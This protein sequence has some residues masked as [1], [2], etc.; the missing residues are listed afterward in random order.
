[1]DFHGTRHLFVVRVIV[2]DVIADL[3]SQ[4]ES[5]FA[6]WAGMHR[7]WILHSLMFAPATF[8]GYHQRPDYCRHWSL[9]QLPSAAPI[10]ASRP[11]IGHC[12]RAKGGYRW[13]VRLDCLFRRSLPAGFP[14]WPVL[15]I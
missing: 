7:V 4:K 12:M 5:E 9:R 14:R 10:E 15:D 3:V 2:K 8:L 11:L 13:D 6:V 1:M